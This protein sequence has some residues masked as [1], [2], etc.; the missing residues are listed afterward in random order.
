MSKPVPAPTTA[1]PTLRD[2]LIALHG[3]LVVAGG[4]THAADALGET[5]LPR[6]LI[7]ADQLSAKA[8]EAIVEAI[9]ELDIVQECGDEAALDSE[10]PPCD[11]RAGIDGEGR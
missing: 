7:M 1:A 5:R 9:E 11:M 3:H 6:T 4:L 8:Y 2:R 10:V